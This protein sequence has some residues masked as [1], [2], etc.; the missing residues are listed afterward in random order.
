MIFA[1][2]VLR[3]LIQFRSPQRGRGSSLSSLGGMPEARIQRSHSS[4]D[5]LEC[6]INGA[7]FSRFTSDRAQFAM[8]N[9]NFPR[10]VKSVMLLLI[11]IVITTWCH[12]WLFCFCSKTSPAHRSTRLPKS[13]GTHAGERE[14]FGLQRKARPRLQI[15]KVIQ[16]NLRQ[17]VGI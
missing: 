7:S 14:H 12:Q 17:A 8:R 11:Q 13:A 3:T 15:R 10:R 4:S 1:D 2:R 6:A 9:F 16:Q 5:S